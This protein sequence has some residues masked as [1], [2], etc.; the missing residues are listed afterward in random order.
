M[1]NIKPP[2]GIKP[3]FV[4]EEERIGDLLEAML[5]YSNVGWVIPKE[6]IEELDELNKSHMLRE[7][8]KQQRSYDQ[9]LKDLQRK[10]NKDD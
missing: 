5:R 10:E 3:K 6:W 1:A 9:A 7:D 8:A 2:I 4:W